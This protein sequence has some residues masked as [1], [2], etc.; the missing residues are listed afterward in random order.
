MEGTGVD[1]WERGREGRIGGS[2]GSVSGRKGLSFCCFYCVCDEYTV[3]NLI[4]NLKSLK[5]CDLENPK[6][7]GAW[8]I[9]PL[10]GWNVGIEDTRARI[11]S[12]LWLNGAGL[13][14][15]SEL[16]D[17]EGWKY[18]VGDL[19]KAAF[20]EDSPALELG[21]PRGLRLIHFRVLFKPCSDFLLLIANHFNF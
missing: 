15:H 14:Y 20:S 21:P 5:K 3:N 18:H 17:L 8:R 1:W 19:R 12:S 4:P 11:L 6:L 9:E 16:C 7:A 2:L 10:A 13:G